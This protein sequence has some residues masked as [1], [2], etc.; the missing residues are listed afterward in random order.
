MSPLE[1]GLARRIIGL[2]GTSFYAKKN[3]WACRY[4]RDIPIRQSLEE[5]GYIE[6]SSLDPLSWKL[7]TRGI[8]QLKLQIGEFSFRVK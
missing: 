2:R 4:Y 1:I 5:R 6:R 7:T 3:L 8:D